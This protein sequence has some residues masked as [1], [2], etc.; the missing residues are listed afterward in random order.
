MDDLLIGY[1]LKALS[2]SETA[3]VER[4]LATDPCA[5]K[6]LARVRGLL[7]PL[8][9]DADLAPPPG[10]A[11]ATIGFVAA[12]LVNNK[13]TIEEPPV[14]AAPVPGTDVHP[15][16]GEPDSIDF[17]ELP[18]VTAARGSFPSRRWVE[19]GLTAAVAFLAVGMLTTGIMK[20]R[21][22]NAVAACKNQMMA[23][24]TGLSNYADTHQDQFPKVGTARVPTAG[25]F[26][27]ELVN[28]G[29]LPAT[30]NAVCP[31][32]SPADGDLTRVAYVYT[33][34][35]QSSGQI[36]GIRRHMEGVSAEVMPLLADLPTPS[37]S[38]TSGP[39]SP[40]GRGQNILYS[41]GHVRY[42]LYATV[43][44]NGD[45]IYQNQ[46]GRVRAGLHRLDASLGRAGD[47]P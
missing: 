18:Q 47:V 22:D 45:D 21:H 24:H 1:A 5:E 35:Y 41:D 13:V 2:P 26:A 9:A 42:S 27:S 23:L 6:K 12:H 31:S 15:I 28:A 40:H 34:G 43:G 33:L 3:E 7:E 44:P 16:L 32:E 29:T 14:E 4:L 25:A 37:V 30:V 8:A 36:Q 38:P 19:L 20:V 17:E 10:L 39:M 46:D 11:V